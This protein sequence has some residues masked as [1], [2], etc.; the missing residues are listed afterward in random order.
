MTVARGE[1]SSKLGF[2]LA[3]SGSAVGL[4]NIW[5]FPTQAASNGGG[6]FLLVYLLLA[7]CLAFPALMAELIIGRHAKSNAVNALRLISTNRL[8]YH[9]GSIT[10]YVGIITASLILCFYALVAGWMLS[11]FLAPL[12]ELTG[13]QDVADWLTEF[14]LYRNILFMLIFLALT[15]AI[16]SRGV[17]EGIEK[18]SARLMPALLVLLLLLIVYVLTLDG[19]MEGVKTYL[20]PDFSRV[21][22]LKLIISALGQAFFSLSLGVGTMLIY[23]SYISHKENLF[24][25]GR[26]VTFV[27]I[28]IAV[29]AGLLILP[30]MFVAQYN[31]VV[32]FDATGKLISEDTLIFTVLPALFNTMGTIGIFISFAFFL[33]MSI[34]ALTSSISM[35]EVPVAY[36][37]ENHAADRQRAAQGIGLIIALISTVIAFNFENLFSLT[38]HAT[39]RYSQP[40]LGFALCIFAGWLWHRNKVLAEI[41]LG[42]AEVKQS[43][44][45]KIWPPYIRYICPL[46][47]LAVFIHLAFYNL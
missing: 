23:G 43:L 1:F 32:I 41:K 12:A 10:G 20:I 26:M 24:H 9:A 21:T 7:F 2:V 39:T 37:V 28:G 17:K 18:W 42:Y 29:M 13:M 5:G 38:V 31:G 14:G 27:D 3:A 36:V 34:A 45:W 25:L 15:V 40:L 16:I 19:A 30:A 11:F 44:F 22:D 35:L 8:S 47:I 46:S 4:G 6:A 33:L